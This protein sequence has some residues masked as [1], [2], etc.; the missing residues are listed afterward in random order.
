MS[1]GKKTAKSN[2]NLLMLL[3]GVVVGV[4]GGAVDGG[5]LGGAVGDGVCGAVGDG[6]GGAVGDGVLG[7]FVGSA[8]HSSVSQQSTL[9]DS[10]SPVSLLTLLQMKS[11]EQRIGGKH[12]LM[13]VSFP[14]LTVVTVEQL[15]P[16]S[17]VP[18]SSSSPQS[19]LQMK[20]RRRGGVPLPPSVKTIDL[21]SLW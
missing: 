5:V 8:L 10:R 1:R 6:V 9:Q 21:I 7:G 12:T 15:K 19:P 14:A 18:S 20:H 17:Q 3:P 13:L 2:Y 4:L 11:D 16:D